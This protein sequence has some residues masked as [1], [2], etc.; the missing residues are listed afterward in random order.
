MVVEYSKI[1]STFSWYFLAEPLSD[2]YIST[3][4]D[5]QLNDSFGSYL[6]SSDHSSVASAF[7]IICI[8]VSLREVYNLYR[9]LYKGSITFELG[10]LLGIYGVLYASIK[11]H[12]IYRIYYYLIFL[13]LDNKLEGKSS[14]EFIGSI[15]IFLP[16][17]INKL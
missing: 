12:T 7:S 9:G 8:R 17:S 15:L 13:F 5:Y 3:K 1:T 6:Y 14:P 4:P 2:N 10:F 16:D 11:K